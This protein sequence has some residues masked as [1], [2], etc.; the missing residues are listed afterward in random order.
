MITLA[1]DDRSETYAT[2]H[3]A[4]AAA[5]T[6]YII[7]AGDRLLAPGSVIDQE[8]ISQTRKNVITPATGC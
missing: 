4:I 5:Q 1:D 3:E 7:L 2:L 8:P 6:S